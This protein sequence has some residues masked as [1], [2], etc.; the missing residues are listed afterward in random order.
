[1]GGAMIDRDSLASLLGRARAVLFDFD[2]PMCAL[3]GRLPRD[4]SGAPPTKSIAEKIKKVAQDHW[5]FLA[6]RVEHCDDSHDILRLLRGMWEA[7]PNGLSPM[8]LKAAEDIVARAEDEAARSAAPAQDIA[9]LVDVLSELGLYLAIVSNN[10]EDPIRVFLDRP[11]ILLG[12]KFDGVFGRDPEDARLMK[13]S[14]HC[15][16]RAIEKLSLDASECLLVGD[17][18]SDLE[19][20]R[21]AGTRF[22][23]YTHK[24]FRAEQMREE[25]ADVVVSSHQPVIMA[26]REILAARQ[27]PPQIFQ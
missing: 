10:A 13:P 2:G 22:L 8:P 21:S 17:K 1:M 25:G 9:A 19:A 6:P 26:A 14:P 12:Q 24:P 20:A 15:V 3:F 11:G 18:L 23:G 27:E 5:G 16:L 4:P 7:D